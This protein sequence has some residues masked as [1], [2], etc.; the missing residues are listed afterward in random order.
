MNEEAV[1]ELVN[2]SR[3][4]QDFFFTAGLKESKIM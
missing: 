2:V 4:F 3:D 1:C